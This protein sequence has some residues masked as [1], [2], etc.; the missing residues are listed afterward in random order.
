MLLKLLG[1]WD[2]PVQG[3]SHPGIFLLEAGHVGP[4]MSVRLSYCSTEELSGYR[5]PLHTL[6]TQLTPDKSKWSNGRIIRIISKRS[7]RTCT[8]SRGIAHGRRAKIALESLKS[9]AVLKGFQTCQEALKYLILK[10]S[11]SVRY[12]AP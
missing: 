10:P 3:P 7:L 9:L 5:L 1:S 12:T 4:G 11:F 2:D 8:V 6:S